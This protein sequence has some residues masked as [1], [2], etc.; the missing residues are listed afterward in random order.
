MQIEGQQPWEYTSST[1]IR[2]IVFSGFISL[3]YSLLRYLSPYASHY[4]NWTI[5]SPYTL[6]VAPRLFITLLSFIADFCVYK[7]ASLCYIRPWQCMEVF[8]SSYVMLIYGTRTFSNTL[9]L[10]LMSVVLWRVSLS[11]VESS[12]VIRKETILQ[13]LYQSADDLCDKVRIVR[14]RTNLPAYN[15]GDSFILSVVVTLGAFIRPTFIIYTFVPIAYWLQRGIM[16]KELDFH[17]FNMRSLS[18]LP[19]VCFTFLV[20][21]LADSFYYESVTA[22]EIL[23][24]NLTANSFIATP[25]NFFLYNTEAKNLA[26]HGTHPHYLHILINLPLLH[27]VLAFIGLYY[28]SLYMS[29]LFSGSSITRKPKI[30]SMASMMLLS[31]IVPV[32]ILSLAP[33][34]EARFLLP[35]LPCLVLLHSDK[36]SLHNLFKIKFAKHFLFLMWH[37]WNIFCVIFFGFLHQGGVTRAM[38]SV[39][40]YI[41]NQPQTFEMPVHVYFSHMYTPPTFLLMRHI[42]VVAATQ[43]GRKFKVARSVYSHH[44]AGDTR[45]EQMN[46]LLYSRLTNN[47]A[48]NYNV[49]Y[50]NFTNNVNTSAVN[51]GHIPC[52]ILL[53]LP[54]NIASDLRRTDSSL[55]HYDLVQRFPLHFTLDYPPD[56]TNIYADV[57]QKCNEACATRN[58]FLEF[59]LELYKVKLSK[60]ASQWRV[61]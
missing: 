19:G 59:S 48:T 60:D 44:I 33:H 30:Y 49:T 6:L 5:L 42:D 4:L 13:D 56:F 10:I 43:E 7:I 8:A 40:D 38:I 32:L 16:T 14:I 18:L 27:G 31:F 46:K 25:I 53:C 9:E 15:Y 3:P 29:S 39:H 24:G 11:I 57:N 28:T 22:K 41:Q 51:E 23:L 12:K 17:Y 1:P 35:T 36:V 50:T 47:T 55:L 2:S 61:K 34:Q 37:T 20:C 54:G 21:V 26:K 45:I 58:K 52:E